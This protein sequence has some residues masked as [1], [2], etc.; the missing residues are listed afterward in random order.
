MSL[1][2]AD[3]T[4]QLAVEP[5]RD[6]SLARLVWHPKY[7]Y[8][9]FVT[10]LTGWTTRTILVL[11][12]VVGNEGNAYAALVAAMAGLAASQ[13]S[14]PLHRCCLAISLDKLLS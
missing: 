5:G 14:K 1:K 12:V 6:P 7:V 3:A 11:Y 10:L 2:L 13:G 8:K 9:E 4:P